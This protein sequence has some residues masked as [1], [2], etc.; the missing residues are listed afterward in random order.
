MKQ[1]D[2]QEINRIYHE[3]ENKYPGQMSRAD[4]FRKGLNNGDIDQETYDIARELYDD[5]WLL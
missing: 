3:L 4:A 2:K 1:L 5:L